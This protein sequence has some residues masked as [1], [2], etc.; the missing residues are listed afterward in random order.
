MIFGIRRLCPA[1]A[2]L[3][4][5]AV[6]VAQAAVLTVTKEADTLDG[7]CTPLD[8]SLREAIVAANA[9]PGT[10]VILLPAGTYLL[11]RFGEG[12]DLGATGDL[13]ITDDVVILGAG[14]PTTSIDAVERDRILHVR[15]ASLALSGVRLSRGRIAG[16]GGA[17]LNESGDVELSRIHFTGNGTTGDTFG[18]AIY[19]D[20][21][22]SL[23]VT[24]STFN[25]N[26]AG[27]S[28]GAIAAQGTELALRNVTFLTNSA[29]TGFGGALYFFRDLPATINNVTITGN[30]AARN[31]GGVYAEN[32]AFIGINAPTFS[33]T[34]LAGNTGGVDPDCTGS[35]QSAGYN[36]VGVGGGCTGFAPAKNDLQGTAADP[37]FQVTGPFGSFGGP[38]PT[39]SI[40][41]Q[42]PALNAG[43]PAAPGSGPGACEPVDQ[44]GAARPGGPRCDAGAFEVTA[45]CVPGEL[46]LCLNGGRYKVTATFRATANDTPQPARAVTLTDDTGYLYFFN[47]KNVEATIKVL[48][49]CGVNGRYWVFAS[50]MTNVEVMLTVT[51]TRTGAV[52]NY[53]NPLNRP[54]RPIQDTV[55]FNTCP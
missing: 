53:T 41:S 8:C 48:N 31:G 6:P 54:F 44:R 33:N 11:T 24:E 36:V 14:A 23:T 21:A 38:M 46:T 52:K 27:A 28:G 17:L 40:P 32:S 49:G 55:A 22:G 45:A 43:N 9:G 18:G 25:L 34:I 12:E 13:D 26:T 1:L 42:S 37:L 29:L 5:T 7:A 16:N 51:D 3:A 20:G 30:T 10:D 39:V 47:P 50:G 4:L 2:L 35:T 15:N 19:T